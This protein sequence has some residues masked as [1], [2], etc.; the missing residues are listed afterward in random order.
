MPFPNVHGCRLRDPGNFQQNS[1]RT[2]HRN[3]EGKEY[4]V[5]IGKLKGE[6]AMTEQSYRYDKTIWTTESAQTHCEDHGGSFEA[7]T[8]EDNAMYPNKILARDF[9]GYSM[10][11]QTTEAEIWL[12][13]EIGGGDW[14]GSGISAKQFANDLKALGKV[15]QISLRLNSP[16]GDVF[17]G[18]AI[19]N[20]LKQNPA[21]VI[22][23]VD[24]LA[25]SIASVIAMAG[26]EIHMAGNATMMIH[27]AWGMTI[28]NSADMQAM[29]DTLAKLDGT[30]TGTYAKR[31]GKEFEVI[32]Q[33]MAD[34]TW[35]NAQEAFD[36]GFVDRIT[37]ELKLAAHFDLDKFKFKKNP[38]AARMPMPPAA[39]EPDK[40]EPMPPD[41]SC[42]DQA[43]SRCEAILNKE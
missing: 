12:Y 35:M 34:E 26:D 33:M 30:L 16:G 22:V 37:E 24:G 6:D 13:E 39:A 7:A 38:P 4:N 1:F 29:A 20:I 42:F 18:I 31:T 40:P 5:T 9:K 8:E 17:D 27:K 21:R 2:M 11:A 25:A 10:K 19:Y 32:S 14:F 36:L 15:K 41:V 43:I 28:G 23:Y 3:H